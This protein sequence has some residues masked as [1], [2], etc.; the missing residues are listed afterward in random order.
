MTRAQFDK[1]PKIKQE[2]LKEE[3][4]ARQAQGK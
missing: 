1:L 2:K 3:V 4:A